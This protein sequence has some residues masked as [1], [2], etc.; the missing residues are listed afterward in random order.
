MREIN[1]TSVGQAYKTQGA[2]LDIK[3]NKTFM[4]PVE[5][6]FI[7]DGFNVRELDQEHIQSLVESYREGRMMPALVIRTTRGGF[8]VIDGHHRLSAAKIAGVHRLECK[9]FTGTEAEQIAFMVSS[10]QGLN[11]KPIDRARAYRRL[12]G[13]GMTKDEITEAVK[14]SR[15]HVDNLLLMLEAGDDVLQAI[16]DGEVAA[17]EVQKE[18]RKSGGE[19]Q[20]K[21]MTAVKKARVEGGKAKL[22]AFTK[23]HH[24]QVMEILSGMD[25]SLIGTELST[26]VELWRSD[27]VRGTNGK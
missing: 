3:V 26:L 4:V 13:L 19:A 23:K 22:R 8:K 27:S 24:D 11:L 17:T 1:A 16:K 7:E 9:E 18:M 20:E 12:I 6:L 15:S 21:I 2:D 14:R 5:H 25:A 10:S